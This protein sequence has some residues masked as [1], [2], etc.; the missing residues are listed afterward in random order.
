[1]ARTLN[2]KDMPPERRELLIRQM[3]DAVMDRVQETLFCRLNHILQHDTI[4]R[5]GDDLQI[6]YNIKMHANDII[7]F[8]NRIKSCVM[9]S[10]AEVIECD[11]EP[12]WKKNN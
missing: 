1:M 12:W 7:D 9:I 2:L 11:S 5:D 10:D 6:G 4:M 3:V 8:A